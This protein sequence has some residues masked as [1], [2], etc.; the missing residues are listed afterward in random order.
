MLC[1]GQVITIAQQLLVVDHLC[2]GMH[3]QG[4]NSQPTCT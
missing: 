4:L 2:D 1:V 3:A